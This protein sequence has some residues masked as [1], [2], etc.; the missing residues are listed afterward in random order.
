MM[1]SSSAVTE[2]PQENFW[3]KNRWAS[4]R[5][6]SGERR[7]VYADEVNQRSSDADDWKLSGRLCKI[8]PKAARLLTEGRQATNPGHVFLLGSWDFCNRYFLGNGFLFL[9][10]LTPATC[11]ASKPQ[12][13]RAIHSFELP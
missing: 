7:R 3:A 4:L 2:A 5:S 13:L 12:K 6:M 8:E 1:I 11:R 10:D 9:F